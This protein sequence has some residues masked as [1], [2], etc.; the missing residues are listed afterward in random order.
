MTIN[1][2]HAPA[3]VVTFKAPA[4]GT[5][6]FTLPTSAGS[7][8]Q[9]LQT[10]GSGNLSWATATAS[11]DINGLTATTPASDDTLPLYDVSATA[12]RKA[13]AAEI[14]ALASGQSGYRTGDLYAPW[15]FQAGGN[16]SVAVAGRVVYLPF[17]VG[18]KTTFTRIAYETT[19]GA[20]GAQARMGLY[21]AV[22]GAPSAKLW[23]T[24]ASTGVQSAAT[25]EITISQ[26]VDPGAYFI[27]WITDGTPTMRV[28]N[29]NATVSTF[30][31]GMTATNSQAPVGFTETSS[32]IA[33]PATAGTLTPITTA[34][35]VGQWL[36]VA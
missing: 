14:A 34:I 5:W 16:T 29:F 23:E 3:G 24:G 13:T 22:N 6:T 10:D 2:D 32:G 18:R 26:S 27:A 7:A 35:C 19:T 30:V 31:M 33:L 4:S 28:L 17:L 36:K 11:I 21:S 9:Y 15:G 1:F 25:T 20:A 8:N 12:N